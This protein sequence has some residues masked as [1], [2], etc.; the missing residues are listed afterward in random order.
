[1]VDCFDEGYEEYWLDFS[2][3]ENPYEKGTYEY[4]TWSDGWYS[5]DD[6]FNED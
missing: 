6:E 3:D 1:M 4:S 5:A 2:I